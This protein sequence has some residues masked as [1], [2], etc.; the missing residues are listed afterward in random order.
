ME[1]ID[2]GGSVIIDDA[3]NSNPAGAKAALDTLALMEGYKILITPGMVELGV[4]EYELNKSFGSQAAEVCDY[5]IAV[6][7]KQAKA[8]IDGLKEAGY[9]EEKSFVAGD[10]NGALAKADSLNAGESRKI[11]LL[12]ND[13]PDNY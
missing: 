13:L 2:K 3:F 8:I 12:E 9:P 11:V 4:K 10:L 6:G 5:V 7:E 1:I